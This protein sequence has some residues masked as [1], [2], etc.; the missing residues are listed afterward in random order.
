MTGGSG[1]PGGPTAADFDAWNEEKKALHAAGG[2]PI[3]REGQVWWCAVGVGI[4][5]EVYGKG[6]GGV[7][8]PPFTRP[9]IV[10][11]KLS[12]EACVIVPV[13]SRQ[14]AR[15]SDWYHPMRWRGRDQWAM[16]HQTRMVSAARFRSRMVEL[17]D[18]DFR[19]LRAAFR[20]FMGL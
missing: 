17:P 14:P 19:A 8:G 20:A 18:S 16:L 9:V 1:T 6:P 12:R 7:I 11:R 5:S 15:V 13:T 2:P 4:G 10:L 3:F